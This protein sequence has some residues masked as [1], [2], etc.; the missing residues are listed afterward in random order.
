MNNLKVFSD[1]TAKP[2]LVEILPLHNSLL[3]IPNAFSILT[4]F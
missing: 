3:K 1:I 4:H 2:L